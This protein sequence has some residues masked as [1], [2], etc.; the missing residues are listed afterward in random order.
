MGLLGTHPTLNFASLNVNGLSDRGKRLALF[1]GLQGRVDGVDVL[2]LQETHHGSMQQAETWMREGSGPGR[3]W[4]GR[5]LWVAGGSASRGVAVL[6]G[7]H[8]P[9]ERWRVE[10]EDGD[11]RVCVVSFSAHGQQFRV[12]CVYAPCVPVERVPFFRDVLSAAF[13]PGEEG[14]CS[15]IG[16]DWNCVAD[17]VLD[18]SGGG[19]GRCVGYGDGMMPWMWEG[20]LVD[21]FRDRHPSVAVYS[22]FSGSAGT[23]ARLD[24][25]L[26]GIFFFFFFFGDR[27]NYM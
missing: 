12:G 13:P 5:S 1:G 3:P 6:V 14:V 15:V 11:G 20:E 2:L 16:G 8:V 19:R 4:R 17:A 23:A 25:L 7:E 21:V 10:H 24:R 18:Q 22:H 26:V 27:S 9:V